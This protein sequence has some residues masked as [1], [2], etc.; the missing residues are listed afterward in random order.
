MSELKKK[1]F[2][3]IRQVSLSVFNNTTDKEGYLW[4]VK[5]G[6]KRNI[7]F[8]PQLY[9]D[10][11]SE[12]VSKEIQEKINEA[13][14]EFVKQDLLHS[15]D[16]EGQLKNDISLD[17]VKDELG[18]PIMHM[19]G[20]ENADIAT[21]D[22][23]Q[24]VVD[25]MVENVSYD[26]EK[27]SL[28]ITFNTDADKKDITVDLSDL[29][30]VYTAGNGVSI[31]DDGAISIK[32]AEGTQ[33]FIVL[34]ENGLKVYNIDGSHIELGT[35]I[36]DKEGTKE[37]VASTEKIT[38]VLQDIY[39]TISDIKA[40]ALSIEGDGKSVETYDDPT[41]P[42][43]KIVSLKTETATTET[44][45]AGHI[46]IIKSGD[47]GVYAQMYYMTNEESI[48][49]DIT[50]GSISGENVSVYNATISNDVRLHITATD[51]VELENVTLSGEF[52]K[53]T[54]HALV[55]INGG[56]SLVINNMIYDETVTGYNALEIGLTSTDAYTNIDISNCQFNGTMQNNA[57]LIFGTADNAVVNIKNCHFAS[58]SNCLRISNKFNAKNV[59]VNVIDCSVGQWDT[60][61]KWE[62]F[63]ICEDYTSK[64]VE[65]EQTN[66]LFGDG[67]ITVNFVNLTYQGNKI[68]N[69][70]TQRVTY[71]YN[72][73]GKEV[74]EAKY[75]PIVTFK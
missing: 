71:V 64:S 32:I 31:S 54:A 12:G 62:G 28:V 46:E 15:F 45:N 30:D 38:N 5:D 65:A 50:N 29:V 2:K 55:T 72:D 13:F 43:K 14:D 57:I 53:S 21:L 59:V 74:T 40:E 39:N 61:P 19:R 33:D 58:V 27:H 52:P 6:T 35:P 17:I 18:N 8:G 75:C 69:E 41:T 47:N 1:D 24:F 11:N 49:G 67:K 73:Y 68:L 42:T 20:T 34:N 44:I 4:L 66:N 48:T 26:K 51:N 36:T 56:A 37:I 10:V 9:S 70:D 22:M 7:Y 60:N 25:G 23:S 3:G 63:L 16:E